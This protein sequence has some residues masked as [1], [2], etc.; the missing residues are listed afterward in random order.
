MGLFKRDEI[1]HWDMAT[2]QLLHSINEAGPDDPEYQ[3][4]LD[5]LDKL[6]KIKNRS[7]RN[8]FER[9]SPDTLAIVVGNL[10]GILV[11]VKYEQASV[12]TSK[13]MNFTLKDKQ[14]A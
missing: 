7:N 13:A 10:V 3:T 11:I 8:V 6:M 4:K 2:R 1:D 14:G 9:I 5:Q 12:L